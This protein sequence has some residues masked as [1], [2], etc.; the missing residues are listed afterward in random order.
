M[1]SLPPQ[2]GNTE[3]KC[4]LFVKVKVIFLATLVLGLRS[5]FGFLN[6]KTFVYSVKPNVLSREK[7][8][9]VKYMDWD[10]MIEA[11]SLV[12]VC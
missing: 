5:Q 12:R 1:L 6:L 10:Q 2:E 9:C 3:R 7:R 8:E 11:G 4:L